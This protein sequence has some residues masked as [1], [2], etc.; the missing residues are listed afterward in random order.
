MENRDL[1]ATASYTGQVPSFYSNVDALTH[2]RYNKY[3][4]I[5]KRI[6]ERDEVLMKMIRAH[7]EDEEKSKIYEALLERL[8]KHP[9]YDERS[10]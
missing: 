5:R 10:Y 4:P 1:R 7:R 9:L 6:N 2:N 8:E 3:M